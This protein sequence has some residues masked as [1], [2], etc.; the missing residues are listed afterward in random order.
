MPTLKETVS[1]FLAQERIAVVGVSRDGGQAA[2]LV[3]KKLRDAG[4]RVFPG[5]IRL[6]RPGWRRFRR[7]VLQRNQMRINGIMD[8][9]VLMRSMAG[10]MGH[11][12][13]A[14]TRNLRA[15]FFQRPGAKEATTV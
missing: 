1:D 4:Y 12:K 6:S 7:K 10:L 3:Y 5:V 2:N 14:C 13:Q 8:N 9:G 15:S 11:V